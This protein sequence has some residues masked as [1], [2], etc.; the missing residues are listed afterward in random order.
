[1]GYSIPPQ[2]DS[3]WIGEVGPGPSYLDEESDAQNNEFTNRNTTFLAYNMLHLAKILKEQD[4]YP[5]YGNSRED[6]DNGSRWGFQNPEY[7]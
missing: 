7:R 4:G 6:W 1:V 3:G 5:K 2:A